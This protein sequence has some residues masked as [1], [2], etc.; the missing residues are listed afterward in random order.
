VP[1]QRLWQGFKALIRAHRKLTHPAFERNHVLRTA[2]FA[3]LLFLCQK[4][5]SGTAY[6][7]GGIAKVI[8]LPS[9]AT[10]M[11]VP[12]VGQDSAAPPTLVFHR[13]WL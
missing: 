3:A 7:I 6:R 11:R 1:R 4:H 8:V 12:L 13:E 2:E 9:G 10:V 5:D